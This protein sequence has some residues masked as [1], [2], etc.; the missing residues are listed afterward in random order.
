M[1]R[2]PRDINL[3]SSTKGISISSES[4]KVDKPPSPQAEKTMPEPLKPPSPKDARGSP[5][6]GDAPPSPTRAAS[7]HNPTGTYSNPKTVESP[8]ASPSSP[9]SY[10]LG[11]VDGCQPGEGSSEPQSKK[12]LQ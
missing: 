12:L 1:C 10:G 11:A 4:P 6:T 9:R 2:V 7:G 3:D 5:S 8:V